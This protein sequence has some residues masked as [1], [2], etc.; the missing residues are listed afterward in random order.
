MKK[1]FCFLMMSLVLVV[2]TACQKEEHHEKQVNIVEYFDYKCPY[3]KVF[4]QKIMKEIEKKYETDRI[5]YQLIDVAFLGNDAIEG[6]RAAQA[7]QI[8]A[9]QQFMT[10]HHH[11]IEQQP[12]HEG[13]WLTHDKIDQQIDR[14][15]ISTEQK[16]KIKK[17]YKTENS[18]AWKRAEKDIIRANNDKVK[19]VPTL[20]INGE[21]VSDPLNKDEV[22]KKIDD[23]L[24]A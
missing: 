1:I 9:P 12:N 18:E 23:A 15:S 20:K 2:F 19:L 7:V 10:F 17:E 5:Q 13:K 22:F 16:D 21:E 24:K 8:V 14:L 4:D 6:A 11:L 3:C